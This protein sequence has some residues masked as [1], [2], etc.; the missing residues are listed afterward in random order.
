MVFIFLVNSEH[1][2]HVGRKTGNK[3]NQFAAALDLKTY[4]LKRS[5]T[6]FTSHMR[7]QCTQNNFF[8]GCGYK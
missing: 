1:V 7:I 3:K 8:G 6:E 5:I 2:A 4:A